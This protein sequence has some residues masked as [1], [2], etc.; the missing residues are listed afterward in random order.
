MIPFSYVYRKNAPI[1]STMRTCIV[2]MGV[3]GA[4]KT[5]VGEALARAHGAPFCDADDLHTPAAVAKMA[6]GEALTDEDRWPWIV[7]VR[8]AAERAA[9]PRCVVACSCLR[10]AYRDVLRATEMRVVF[11]Y[12]PVDPAVVMDRL[13]RRRGHFMKADMLAS[14]LATL[15]PPDADEAITVSQARVDDI[16]AELRDKI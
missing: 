12:L 11:V 1:F 14:Q 4:G 9:N 10:R 3:A 13:Q 6:R 5:T 15:E 2:V 8:E 7:R 16:V